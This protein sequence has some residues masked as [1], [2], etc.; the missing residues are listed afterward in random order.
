[1]QV[2]TAARDRLLAQK[3]YQNN[4]AKRL[5]Y[6]PLLALLNRAVDAR[7]FITFESFLEPYGKLDKK[8]RAS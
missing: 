5:E 8:V 2:A 3:N 6:E 7:E 4:E 1:M